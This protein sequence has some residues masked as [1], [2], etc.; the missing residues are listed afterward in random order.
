MKLIS[1][2]RSKIAALAAMVL[3]FGA[4]TVA[5]KAPSDV[6]DLVG[7]RGSSG[8][9]ELGQRGY[10][11]VT[12][13]RGVQYWW[14]AG[15]S[16]CIGI[17]V[18]QGRYKSVSAAS[19]EKCKQR[20]TPASKTS[21][22]STQAAESACMNEINSQYGGNVGEVNVLHAEFSQA[23]TEVTLEAVNVRGEGKNERWRCLSS[24]DGKIS[25]VRVTK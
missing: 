25:D 9:S 10:S 3:I 21:S 20:N 19:A 8:E 16:A 23:N 2:H 14:N 15:S 17:K 6:A 22:Q 7:A 13:N 18:A 4:T 11:Y 1:L 5:A 24:S 12:M